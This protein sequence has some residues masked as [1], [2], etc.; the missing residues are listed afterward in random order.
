MFSLSLFKALPF[1][2]CCFFSVTNVSLQIHIPHFYAFSLSL[3]KN[4]WTTRFG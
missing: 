2:S 3:F 4:R 1:F